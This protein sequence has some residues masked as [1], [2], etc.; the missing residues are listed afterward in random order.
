MAGYIRTSGVGS[1]VSARLRRAAAA[2]SRRTALAGVPY[3]IDGGLVVRANALSVS[4]GRF[5]K[6]GIFV[7]YAINSTPV[8]S[9]SIDS[10]VHTVFILTDPGALGRI[11]DVSWNDPASRYEL[12]L[13]STFVQALACGTGEFDYVTI[14]AS[15]GPGMGV[16]GTGQC[17]AYVQTSAGVDYLR[18][19][20]ASGAVREIANSS[21]NLVQF[22][23]IGIDGGIPSAGEIAFDAAGTIYSGG[24]LLTGD[25]TLACYG[26]T[27]DI[28]LNPV[29]QV[30][31][32]AAIQAEGYK[33]EDGTAG[34]DD[35][36]AGVPTSLTAKDGLVTA[37]SKTTPVADGTYTF[38][39]S[40][41]GTVVSI[42]VA[43]GIIT[44]ITTR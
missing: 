5:Q 36:A 22:D 28:I 13:Y 12:R 44:G 40:A 4:G 16:P 18:V 41:A 43:N 27:G 23:G 31:V 9:A 6:D 32:H 2:V 38:D 39:G 8:F 19:K 33:S 29:G 26:V 10:G 42:T 7:E 25:L 34:I 3:L 30:T 11:L 21:H 24:G 37:V 35:S 15:G 20:F 14:N 1:Q 17:V